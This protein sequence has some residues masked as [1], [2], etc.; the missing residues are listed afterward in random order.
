MLSKVLPKVYGDKLDLNH[1]VQPDNPL[2]SM[3]QRIAG[4]GLP[5]VKEGKE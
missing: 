2:A 1:G 4:T 3:L 5:V